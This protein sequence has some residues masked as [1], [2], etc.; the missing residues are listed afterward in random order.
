L[1]I[2]LLSSNYELCRHHQSLPKQKIVELVDIAKIEAQQTL[3]ERQQTF[4]PQSWD[5][6]SEDPL[7]KY[8]TALAVCAET[9]LGVLNLRW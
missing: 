2:A 3:L 4:H 6:L 9:H 8:A 1:N 5:Y 7:N